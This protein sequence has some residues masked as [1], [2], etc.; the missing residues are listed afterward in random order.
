V[1]EFVDT[2]HTPRNLLIRA[3]R[4]GAPPSDERSRQLQAMTEAWGVTP[5][6]AELLAPRTGNS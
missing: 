5:R 2:R 1:L 4:T 6:L 3:V